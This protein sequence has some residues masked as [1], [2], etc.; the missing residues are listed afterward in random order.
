MK[1]ILRELLIF[2]IIVAV[3]IFI[4]STIDKIMFNYP[5]LHIISTLFV[6]ILLIKYY[7]RRIN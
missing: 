7:R 5:P 3:Y 6:S 4:T 1:I 2:I